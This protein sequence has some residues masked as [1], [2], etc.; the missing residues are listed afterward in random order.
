MALR[1][2]FKKISDYKLHFYN[3]IRYLILKKV[4]A[5]WTKCLSGLDLA[6][7]PHLAAPVLV[8]HLS[9]GGDTGFCDDDTKEPIIQST[10]IKFWLINYFPV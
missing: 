6:H 2:T 9:E 8:R 7:G 1:A 4:L 10:K 3:Q 5:G